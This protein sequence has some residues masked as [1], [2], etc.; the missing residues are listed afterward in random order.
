MENSIKE[1]VT[2][3]AYAKSINAI[4]GE[5]VA[6]PNGDFISFVLKSGDKST[7]PVGGKSQGLNTPSELEVLC[8]LDG[9][10][11]ATAN[12]YVGQGVETFS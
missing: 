10:A 7:I 2:M 4:S 11:V 12:Q 8:F 1:Q 3:R 5:I 9:G 6:G